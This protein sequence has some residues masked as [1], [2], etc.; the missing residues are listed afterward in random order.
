V[1]KL[2]CFYQY[3]IF[4]KKCIHFDQNMTLISL[5]ITSDFYF[6]FAS[7]FFK[8]FSA[9]L[10]DRQNEI[11]MTKNIIRFV[12]KFILRFESNGDVPKKKTPFFRRGGGASS[13]YD[14]VPSSR[15][16][17]LVGPSLKG[18]EVTDMMQKVI[19]D[20]LKRHF[21]HRIK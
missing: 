20:F 10:S 21:Q 9:F 5:V 6:Y 4:L 16:V 17:I 19:F 12:L 18:Y 3:I 11:F 2:S 1:V 13:P 7:A 14:V 8:K 15:P